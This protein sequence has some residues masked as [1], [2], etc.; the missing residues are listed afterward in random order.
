MEASHRFPPL[1]APGSTTETFPRQALQMS[2]CPAWRGWFGPAR[3][4]FAWDKLT[5]IV[6]ANT[7][8]ASRVEQLLSHLRTL[9]LNE[10]RSGDAPPPLPEPSRC[11]TATAPRSSL[12]PC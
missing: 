2:T 9:P 12:A 7:Y 8:P 6:S 11:R 10:P 1:C 5:H 3:S 4:A